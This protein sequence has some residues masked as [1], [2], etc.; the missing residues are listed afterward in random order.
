MRL[1][2]VDTFAQL[3]ENLLQTLKEALA[4]GVHLLTFA[5]LHLVHGYT[6]A[7]DQQQYCAGRSRKCGQ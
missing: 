5:L 4:L 2:F 7:G 6:D 3:P 1:K